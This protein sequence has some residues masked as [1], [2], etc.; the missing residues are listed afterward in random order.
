MRER[1]ARGVDGDGFLNRGHIEAQ[2]AHDALEDFAHDYVREDRRAMIS[3]SSSGARETIENLLLWF[4]MGDGN[5]MFTIEIVDV[6]GDRLVLARFSVGYRGGLS[7]E[8]LSVTQFDETVEKE[9]KAV[10][11]DP[12]DLDAALAELDKLHAE[13][14]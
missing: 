10:R 2:L 12:D 8:V 9:Q 14:G 1:Y 5:P 3:I 11:F 4:E 7:T 6:R 13:L